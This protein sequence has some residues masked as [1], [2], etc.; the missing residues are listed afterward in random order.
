MRT[1]VDEIIDLEFDGTVSLTPKEFKTPIDVRWC[2]GCGGYAI[3]AQTQRILAGLGIPREKIVFVSGIGCSSR[4]PYYMNVYGM[5]TMHGRALA[6]ASGLKIA[7]PDLSVWIATGDGDCLSIGGNHFI[8]AARRNVDLNVIMFNNAVYSLTKGQYSPTSLQGQVTKS[9]PLGV[10]DDPFNPVSLALGSGASL[11]ARC[12]DRDAKTM[13]SMFERAAQ[14]KGFAY[15]EAYANCVIYNDGAFD[16]YTKKDTR[17][18]T[19]VFIEHGKPLVFGA[20]KDK[21]IKLDGSTPTVVSIANGKYS[22]DDLLVHNEKDSTLAFILA[23]MTYNPEL[24]RPMG[25]FMAIERPTY[26]QKVIDQL[27]KYST[28]KGAF[29]YD[30]LLRG[31]DWWEIKE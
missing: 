18:E 20:N 27:D 11:V 28:A 26:D 23:N 21:G 2:A 17:D 24:P 13:Q 12:F 9:S 7:R 4:F 25:V 1:L 6:I 3:L 8:H 22:I 14:H 10:L 15:I 16:L 5:H 19:T 29:D 30:R 31:E